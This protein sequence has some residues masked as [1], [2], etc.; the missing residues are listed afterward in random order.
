YTFG[1]EVEVRENGNFLTMLRTSRRFFRPTGAAATG[2]LADYFSGE[3][4]SEVGLKTSWNHDIWTTVAPNVQQVQ[5]Q[6]AVAEK[7]LKTC[8]EAGPGTP[9]QCK[10]LSALMRAAA[11]EPKLQPQALA[12]IESLQLLSAERIARG[13]LKE[14]GPAT[15]KVIVNPLVLWMW[16][17]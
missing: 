7:G 15:F 5:H 9:A 8:I 16:I 2:G 13:Y 3:A 4:T 1:A 12:Q 17:G 6:L 14:A 10:Q 11:A